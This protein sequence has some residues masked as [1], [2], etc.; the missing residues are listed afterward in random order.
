MINS[1]LQ[2]LQTRLRYF[3]EC[4]AMVQIMLSLWY[5]F[6]E[7]LGSYSRCKVI[8]GVM[9][10]VMG[11][12][13]F[14]LKFWVNIMNFRMLLCSWW[15]SFGFIKFFIW[16]H[17][18]WM[19]DEFMGSSYAF[20]MSLFVLFVISIS[21]DFSTYIIML[22]DNTFPDLPWEL[23]RRDKVDSASSCP[24]FKRFSDTWAVPNPICV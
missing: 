16:V 3:Q 9:P 8:N 24:C 1:D 22:L 18:V 13:S 12:T 6:I 7:F 19:S 23:Y 5:P 17:H 20:H 11:P 14:Y 21:N 2:E 15:S 4:S 10:C